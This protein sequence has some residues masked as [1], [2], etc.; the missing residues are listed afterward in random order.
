M[1][2]ESAKRFLD[3]S[4]ELLRWVLYT[5][6]LPLS[7]MAL[8]LFILSGHGKFVSYEELFGGTEVFLLCITV[9]ATTHVDLEKSNID[10]ARKA[11][12]KLLKMLVFP[13]AVVIAMLFGVVFLNSFVSDCSRCN[14]DTVTATMEVSG[15]E[16]VPP[17]LVVPK[18]HIAN[19]AVFLGIITSVICGSLRIVL[20]ASDYSE[21][22]S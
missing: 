11:Q 5:I 20:V 14:L 6:A 7:P 22:R 8:A 15:N 19:Y 1:F 10:F 2:S 3:I 4:V 18:S 16:I 12:Y 9:F 21:S 13:T 17:L